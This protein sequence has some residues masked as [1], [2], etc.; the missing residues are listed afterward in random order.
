M[1][2][3]YIFYLDNMFENFLKPNLNMF[4]YVNTVIKYNNNTNNIIK[5][6]VQNDQIN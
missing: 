6:K 2:C 5:N 3:I 1:I 4:K